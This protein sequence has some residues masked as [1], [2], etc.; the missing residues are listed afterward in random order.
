MVAALLVVLQVKLLRDAQQFVSVRGKATRLRKLDLGRLKWVSIA[1]ITL[2]VVSGALVPAPSRRRPSPASRSLPPGPAAGRRPR[3]CGS[4]PPRGPALPARRRHALRAAR[5]VG[6]VSRPRRRVTAAP[7]PRGGVPLRSTHNSDWH[8][9]ET[10]MLV[11]M[12]PGTSLW[13][14]LHV[15]F[16]RQASDLCRRAER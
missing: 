3:R 14:R 13:S 11:A 15:D 7:R 10:G 5:P 6:L 9:P 4:I 1:A 12:R 16:R 8:G 2:Y